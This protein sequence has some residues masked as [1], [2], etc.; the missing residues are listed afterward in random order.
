MKGYQFM[1]INYI[2]P[3]LNN[4]KGKIVLL[5]MDG[6]GG[7]PI[8]SGGPTELEAANTPNLDRL[9]TEGMLGQ[10]IPIRLGVT[11]GSGPAHL[12]LFGYDPLRYEIGRGVL[13]AFGI[14]MK[15]NTGDI[16]ARGNFCTLDPKGKIKDRRAGRIPTEEAIP[17]VEKLKS[18]QI[19][20]VEIEV[21][22]VKEYRFAVVIRGEGLSQEI[23]DTDPQ[24]TGVPP[25]AAQAQT[26]AAEHT[27]DLFNQWIKE[28]LL[29]L[30]EQ[31]KANGITLRGFSTDPGLP[32]FQESFGLHAACI[33]VYPMYRGVSKLVG[34]DIVEFSGDKPEDEFATLGQ[35]WD[36]YDFFFVH[37]K[38]TD[39]KGEDGD[40]YG[41][42]HV[43]ESVDEAL[44]NLLKLKPDVLIVTG[45]HSTPSTL[46]SHSWHPVPFLLWAPA[47]VRSDDQNQF[48]E[49]ACA[50]GSLGSFPA[51]DTIPLALAHALKLNKYGA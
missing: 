39:S 40:F 38:K 43:I 19:P 27:A 8:V 42:A 7:L 16:A 22:H 17:V 34:M 5:V 28:A 20:E 13:E 12:A 35:V 1:P 45:D 36:D 44:P 2:T 26:P 48:G 49:R 18:I 24:T 11:P 33:A 46:K 3:L 14:N 21:E 31:P 10:T 47:S 4:N 32:S 6:L 51:V 9:A 29:V 41:K 23:D 15:V 50:H 37:I 25:L 30:A